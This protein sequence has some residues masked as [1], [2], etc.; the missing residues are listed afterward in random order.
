M[1]KSR[2]RCH[3]LRRD[4][5]IGR[6]PI[7]GQTVPSWKNYDRQIR[8]KKSQRVLHRHHTLIITRYVANRGATFVHLLEDQLGVKTFWCARDG[9][10]G[11]RAHLA[12]LHYISIAICG[13]QQ[14]CQ[15]HMGYCSKIRS[16]MFQNI[17]QRAVTKI[18]NI[19][20]T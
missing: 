18:A 6:H 11:V 9:D 5:G 19:P 13:D 8:C 7:I 4:I 10:F 1:N 2:K 16:R 3:P 15:P 20:I 17:P 14:F 12:A